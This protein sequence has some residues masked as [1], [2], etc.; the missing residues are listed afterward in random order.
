[1]KKKKFTLD[2]LNAYKTAYGKALERKE[3]LVSL[4]KPFAVA[5]LFTYLLFYYWWVA[6]IAGVIAAFYGYR[7]VMPISIR[8]VYEAKSFRQRNNFINNMT[9]I[10][11]NPDR[12]MLSALETVAERSEGEF[13]EHLY[14]LLTNLQ[15]TNNEEIKKAFDQ[16]I[17]EYKEDVIF[18]LFIEQLTTAMIEGRTNTDT[19]KDI[20]TLHN[21]LK[22]RQ[23]GF[24]AKKREQEIN[25]KII[26]TIVL[27]LILAITFSFGWSVYVDTFAHQFVGWIFST[28]YLIIMSLFYRSFI[29]K[30]GDDSVLEVQ[31]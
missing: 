20:K 24:L 1:M 19:L 11:I 27:G 21:E 7:V 28:T 18:E 17:L 13:Q 15:G 30:L 16:L 10:L 2:E 22:V 23:D 25:Y 6:A 3:L 26:C 4:L 12:T 31:I 29:K 8:R 5:F 9:Q 14:R